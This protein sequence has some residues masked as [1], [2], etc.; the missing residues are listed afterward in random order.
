MG[1]SKSDGPFCTP[2]HGTTLQQKNRVFRGIKGLDEFLQVSIF[3]ARLLLRPQPD[4]NPCKNMASQ[5]EDLLDGILVRLQQT[6][7]SHK[8]VVVWLRRSRRNP[9]MFYTVE[10]IKTHQW[11]IRISNSNKGE[12]KAWYLPPARAD[13]LLRRKATA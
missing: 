2:L 4:E 6:N 3:N 11:I 13:I 5:F 7:R 12:E 10:E 9:G 8:R 1:I